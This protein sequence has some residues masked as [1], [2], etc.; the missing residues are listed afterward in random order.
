MPPNTRDDFSA[1]TKGYLALRANHSCSICSVSTSGPSDESPEKAV[2]IGVA[3]HICA[4]SPGGP[5]YDPNMTPEERVNITN[6]IWLCQTHGAA[7]DRDVLRYS[8][9]ELHRIKD[10]H[11]RGARTKIG[12]PSA[13]SC[14]DDLIA[15]GHDIICVGELIGTSGLQW[16]YRI[17]H[18]VTGD[19]KRLIEY[20]ADFAKIHPYDRFTLCNAIGDGR[21]LMSPLSWRIANNSLEV[22]CTVADRFSR[23]NVHQL[24]TTMATNDANDIFLENR[25][26]ATVS[27]LEALPQKI[28]ETLSHLRGESMWHPETGTRIKEY[29]DAFEG[30]EWLARLVKLETVRMA[31]IPYHYEPLKHTYTPL[32][33]V[34]QVYEVTQLS[35]DRRENWLRFRFEL[36]I[37]GIGRWA[38]EIKIFI[39]LGELPNRLGIPTGPQS[40]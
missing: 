14:A 26:I 28:K 11:E 10:V 2:N 37:E 22:T 40:S 13:Q 30:S 8:R 3:S 15:F 19:K 6:A 18:F 20:S 16:I 25:N 29:F 39:P 7:I 21:Q 5:R 1:K 32:Q 17:D 31:S 12:L 33:C 36:D 35:H 34:N 24:P 4:A 27:G 38:H 9:D 23:T